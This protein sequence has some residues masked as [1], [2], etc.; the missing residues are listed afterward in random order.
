MKKRKI[1]ILPFILVLLLP[2]LQAITGIFS[3]KPL[4]GSFSKTEKPVLTYESWMEGDFQN[5]YNNFINDH[6]GF[7]SFFIRMNNQIEY[8]LFGKINADGIVHGKNG[9]FFEYDYIRT[10]I[11]DDFIGKKI[12]DKKLRRTK[13]IQEIFK[14]KYNKDLI[15]VFAPSKARV[16]NE[17]LPDQYKNGSEKQSNYTFMHNRA[18]ELNIRF[19]DLNEMLIRMK[20]TSTVPVFPECGTHW[21]EYTAFCVADSLLNYSESLLKHTIG[22]LKITQCIK[23]SK[24]QSTDYDMGKTMNLLWEMDHSEMY[25]PEFEIAPAKNGDKPSILTIGDSFYWNIFNLNL[26]EKLYK[27]HKFWLYN[28]RIYPDFYS[29][30]LTTEDIDKKP[31]LDKQDIIYVMI[32]ERFLFK[33]AWRFIDQTYNLYTYDLAP[34][35]HYEYIS[36]VVHVDE[37]FNKLIKQSKDSSVSLESLL[38]KEAEYIFRK[39]NPEKYYEYNGLEAY[40][41]TIRSDSTWYAKVISDAKEKGIDTL[42]SLLGHARYSFSKS[43]PEQ[44]E[45][46]KNIN[47]IM[48]TIRHDSVWFAETK[49]KAAKRYLTPEEML[50]KEAYWQY[51]QSIKTSN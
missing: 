40:K 37:W 43:Y 17:F 10:L 45:I 28:K 3:I 41:K 23:T 14:E 5:N 31:F 6:L 24:L 18:E 34:D 4:N 22:D 1:I 47:R 12:L 46:N 51:Q 49:K 13:Y 30:S 35:Y 19:I 11:G 42:E 32:T 21:S 2:A 36:D 44:F 39:K 8:S 9:N 48:E 50:R 25:Y 38:Y 7:R 33:Y 20:D 16:Y 29:N 27:D 15:L 26:Q